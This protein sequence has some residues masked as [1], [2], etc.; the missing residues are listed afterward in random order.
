MILSGI[1]QKDEGVDD[2]NSKVGRRCPDLPVPCW[3]LGRERESRMWR[4]RDVVSAAWNALTKYGEEG[5]NKHFHTWIREHGSSGDPEH[6]FNPEICFMCFM[7][8]THNTCSLTSPGFIWKRHSFSF[9]FTCFC[10]VWAAVRVGWPVQ[11]STTAQTHP[12][13]KPAE[14]G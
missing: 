4:S 13:N 3:E 7:F 11:R 14:P 6:I 1:N 5:R 10:F 12:D 9:F 2:K 8:W